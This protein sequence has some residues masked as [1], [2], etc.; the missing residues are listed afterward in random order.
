MSSIVPGKPRAALLAQGPTICL[1]LHALRKLV[2]NASQVQSSQVSYTMQSDLRSRL[3]HWPRPVQMRSRCG[4]TV[5]AKRIVSCCE[6]LETPSS[7]FSSRSTCRHV[8]PANIVCGLDTE[9]FAAP[10][11]DIMLCRQQY[12]AL[13]M[14]YNVLCCVYG[15]RSLSSISNGNIVQKCSD[16]CPML[17]DRATYYHD[18]SIRSQRST[19]QSCS[20]VYLLNTVLSSS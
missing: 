1:I 8:R 2:T 15:R 16:L 7:S 11:A 20:S 3:R 9:S 14:C 18:S 13:C 12:R 17:H 10:S 6:C 4:R 19:F 5:A